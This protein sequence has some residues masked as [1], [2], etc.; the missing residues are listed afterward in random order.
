M[1]KRTVKE[2]LGDSPP[3]DKQ[4]QS[5]KPNTESVLKAT[6]AK[7]KTMKG[8][9]ESSVEI[10]VPIQNQFS[11]LNNDVTSQSAVEISANSIN[12]KKK[13][14]PI[15][16]VG[17][18]NF[19][20]ASAIV[21]KIAGD[22]YTLKYMSVGM[23]IQLNNLNHYNTIKSQLISDG[24]E[25]HSHDVNPTKVEHFILSGISKTKID[26]LSSELKSNGF[27][28]MNVS[29]IDIKKPRFDNEGL[30]RVS[31]KGPVHL[32][33]LNQVRLNH[34]VVQ[35]KRAVKHNKITQ[36][37]K[38]Q[39]FGHGIRNCYIKYK[40][41]KCS[42]EHDSSACTSTNTK[43]INCNGPHMATSLECPNRKSFIEMRQKLSSKNNIKKTNNPQSVPRLDSAVMFPKLP[44][45]LSY[46]NN[47]R[48][49]NSNWSFGNPL[50][51][52]NQ[53]PPN[54][55]S[56]SDLFSIDEIKTIFSDVFISLQKCNSKEDQL[57]L[58]F[59]TAAKYIYG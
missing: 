4:K 20:K 13:I 32:K 17:A 25:F 10:N 39:Q 12:S 41:S 8:R 3:I 40:C 36:C 15:T 51:K 38:C 34:T 47:D 57:I 33:S 49:N 35:W 56:E 23:K 31:L 27:E 1:N 6:Q 28:T 14:P 26:D 5:K 24:I 37:R 45:S 29:E 21:S 30:Y 55:K 22:K 44:S 2:I 7:H 18:T 42:L 16:I 46:P 52:T 43:C 48:A 58:I 53:A 11:L 54:K 50:F 9:F 59:A 19:S